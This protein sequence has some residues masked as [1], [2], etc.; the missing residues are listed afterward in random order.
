MKSNQNRLNPWGMI[1]SI[2]TDEIRF[3]RSILG[4]RHPDL[5]RHCKHDEHARVQDEKETNQ[6]NQW[7]GDSNLWPR[8]PLLKALDFSSSGE[9]KNSLLGKE[10]KAPDAIP[11]DPNADSPLQTT[12]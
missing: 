2:K 6:P 10:K 11:L 1:E 12:Q 7:T 8:P 5:S 9:E 3:F 4:I